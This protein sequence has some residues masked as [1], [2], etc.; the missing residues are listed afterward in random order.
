MHTGNSPSSPGTAEDDYLFAPP[1]EQEGET[2]FQYPG[3]PAPGSAFGSE[4]P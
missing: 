3:T 4:C 2:M 1:Q